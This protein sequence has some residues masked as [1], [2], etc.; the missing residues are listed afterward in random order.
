M[1]DNPKTPAPTLTTAYR[2]LRPYIFTSTILL[3]LLPMLSKKY[4]PNYLE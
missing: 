4:L 3:T 1:L 2:N